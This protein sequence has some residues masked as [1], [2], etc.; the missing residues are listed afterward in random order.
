MKFSLLLSAL[1]CATVIAKAADL[2]PPLAELGWKNV[3]W[4]NLNPGAGGNIQSV[5]LDPN[6]PGRLFFCSDM[7]GH[8]R[9]DDYG[10]SWAYTGADLSYSYVN[11][12]GFEPGN[13][14]RIYTGTRG[15]LE[16]SD[17]AGVNWRRVPTIHDSIGQIAV[18]PKHA[19]QIFALPGER[20]RWEAHAQND[21]MRG[22]LARATF[23]C[24]QIAA[25]AGKP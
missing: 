10:Q 24:P 19:Q 7:E 9:S 22:P 21:G 11:C 12:V 14:Q 25:K 1:F 2:T 3:T 8:Y 5:A 6:T 16:I 20:Q 13:A 15:S 18:N 23:T 4:Q 17:N